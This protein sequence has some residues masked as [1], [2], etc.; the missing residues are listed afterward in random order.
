MSK[1]I[2]IID[3]P[4]D[5]KCHG[6][7]AYRPLGYYAEQFSELGMCIR[8]IDSAED[9]TV[10]EIINAVRPTDCPLIP[11]DRV[12]DAIE[13]HKEIASDGAW[14]CGW[15]AGIDQAME[16]LRGELGVTE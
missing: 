14:D 7:K 5:S 10:Q 12:M 15:D 4:D 8:R 16:T 6:C 11:V 1:Y 3:L 9:D 13:S 2:A